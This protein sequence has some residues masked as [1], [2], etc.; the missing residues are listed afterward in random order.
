MT[1]EDLLQLAGRLVHGP[2]PTQQKK[3]YGYRGRIERLLDA[4]PPAITVRTRVTAGCD[5]ETLPAQTEKIPAYLQDRLAEHLR[6][7]QKGRRTSVIIIEEAVLL[8]RYRMPLSFLYELTGDAHAIVLH[9]SEGY[10][11]NAWRLPTYVHYDPDASVAYF[12]QTLAGQVVH[13][14]TA[15]EIR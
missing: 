15:E 6:D 5:R 8:A 10:R 7:L 13:D 11:P 9:V 2:V 14:D 3:V 1:R 4:L 12:E